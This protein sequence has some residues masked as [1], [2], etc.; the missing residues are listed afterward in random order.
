MLK[1]SFNAP[2]TTV[3]QMNELRAREL[4]KG[5]NLTQTAIVINA[6]DNYYKHK[7]GE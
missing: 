1:I 7:K 4:L 5:N 6:I 3:S 2:Q